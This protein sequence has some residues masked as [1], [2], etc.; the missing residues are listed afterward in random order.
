MK[1]NE[2]MILGIATIVAKAGK[3]QELLSAL[4]ALLDPTR[5]EPGCLSYILHQNLD[6]SGEFIMIEKFSDKSAFDYHCSQ[7]YFEQ[8]KAL[9]PNLVESISLKLNKQLDI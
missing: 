4:T 5:K 9:T 8:F 3:E 1:K 2:N 7:S 6:N